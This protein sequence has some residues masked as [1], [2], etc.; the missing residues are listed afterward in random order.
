MKA[1]EHIK[2]TFTS[3]TTLITALEEDVGLSL[4]DKNEY[5]SRF[6]GEGLERN[7]FAHWSLK[8]K[9]KIDLHQ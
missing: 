2:I 6:Y 9:H 4:E 5:S 3:L 7:L 1:K 8:S